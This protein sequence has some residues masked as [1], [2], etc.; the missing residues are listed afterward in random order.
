MDYRNHFTRRAIKAIE[1]AL[2][3]SHNGHFIIED[4]LEK[5]GLLYDVF[6]KVDGNITDTAFQLI[7]C[8]QDALMM[9][10]EKRKAAPVF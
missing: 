5:E 1:F 2:S 8:V 6:W 3:K 4:F 7:A 10:A 9:K